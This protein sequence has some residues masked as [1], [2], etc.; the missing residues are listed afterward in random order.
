MEMSSSGR[1]KLLA[2]QT[3]NYARVIGVHTGLD[4]KVRSVDVEYKIPGESNFRVTTRPI[5]KLVLVV[6]VEE[7]TLREP[8]EPEKTMEEQEN[9]YTKRAAESGHKGGT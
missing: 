5:H 6:P 9:T 3:Y 4:R 2:G 8:E 7:Q 1:T